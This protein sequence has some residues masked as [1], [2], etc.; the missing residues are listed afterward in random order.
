MP[1]L[2]REQ[3]NEISIVNWFTT[4]NG[5]LTDM[6]ECAFRIFDISGGLPGTQIFPTTPGDYEDVTNAPGKFSTGSYYAYDNTAGTGWTPAVDATIG[7]HRIYWKWKATAGS[8]YQEDAEDFEILASSV[9]ST[10]DGYIT[11]QDVR[12]EGV[13]AAIADDDKVLAYISCWQEMIDR[14]C[15]Q[16]FLPRTLTLNFDGNDSNTLFFGV[17]IIS[18]EYIKLND[19]TAEL[20]PL[21]YRVYSGRSYPDDRRNPRIRLKERSDFRDIYDAPTYYNRKFYKGAQNQEVKGVFGFVEDDGTTPCMIKRAL[22]K[23]VIEKLTNPIFHDP[24]AGAAPPVSPTLGPLLEEWTDG[25]KLKYGYAGGETAA[26]KPGMSG[27]TQDP[28]ILDIIRMY[29]APLGLATPAHW[30]W[31]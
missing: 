26:R 4:V 23:L 27:I 21:Y 11:V 19:S 5:V 13:T 14:A 22:T 9:G 24:T 8:P 17:P 31:G 7:T 10:T 30:S 12:D 20:D 1:A 25:H 18:I 15:R 28:E 16:W 3:E 2:A 6:H 29:R